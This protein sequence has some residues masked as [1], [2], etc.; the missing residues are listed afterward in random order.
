MLNLEERVNR[1]FTPDV[2]PLVQEAHR[3]YATGATRR[4]M[5]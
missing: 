1:M 2:R 4:R 3:Y 5:C